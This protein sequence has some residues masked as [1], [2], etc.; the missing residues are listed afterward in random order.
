MF[1]SFHPDK[2]KKKLHLG[3][4]PDGGRRWAVKN[5]VSLSESYTITRKH[6]AEFVPKM[7]QEGVDEI[8][9]YLSSSQNY[10]RENHEILAFSNAIQTALLDDFARIVNQFNIRISAAGNPSFLGNESEMALS[11]LILSSINNKNY[12]INLCIAYNPLEEIIQAQQLTKEN[13]SFTDHLWV[14]NPL[15]LII[16]TGDANL[17]SNFL[18]L[19][20]GFA[21]IFFSDKLFN[22]LSWE[23]IAD[24]I[25]FYNQ[26]DRKYGD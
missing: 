10:R 4:I 20:S 15:D 17:L 22:E 18:P 12:K 6:L 24:W 9:I 3:L 11:E 8:S 19:Q 16:R 13:E 26:L 25:A 14:T 1:D 5:D 2:S 7:F 23:E 21:R